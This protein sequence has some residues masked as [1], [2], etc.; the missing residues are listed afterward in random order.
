MDYYLEKK[1]IK[2]ENQKSVLIDNYG[3][4]YDDNYNASEKVSNKEAFGVKDNDVL[5]LLTQMS[6][7]LNKL[8]LKMANFET[9]LS[10]IEKYAITEIEI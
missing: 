6:D 3:D 5:V 4:Y 8:V 1:K 9:R 2:Q 7:Q 10:D